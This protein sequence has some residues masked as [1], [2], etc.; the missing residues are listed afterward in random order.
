VKVPLLIGANRDE[1]TNL[2]GNPPVSPYSNESSWQ[3]FIS[4]TVS[5]KSA[6][7]GAIRDISILYPDIPA[8]GSP[9]V[10]HGV[11]NATYGAQYKRVAQFAGDN[12]IQRGRRLASQ[13]WTKFNTPV[14][15]YLFDAW[16]IAG[17]PEISG[18]TH[19][20]EIQLVFDNE[21]GDGYVAPWWPR[22]SEFAGNGST[23]L[24]LA[25]LMSKFN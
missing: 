10:F 2:I 17:Q 11:P 6:L 15:S 13:A 7:S 1:G 4:N 19:F 14:F 25:R 24:P 23:L 22:G 3:R 18:T 16:P 9:R 5:N 20:T 12:M 21:Q 8:I